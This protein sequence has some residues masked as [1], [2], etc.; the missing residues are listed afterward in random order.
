[1]S[2]LGKLGLTEE[3]LHTNWN[4]PILQEEARDQIIKHAKRYLKKRGEI[5]SIK[6]YKIG[7]PKGWVC[8]I[9]FS[10]N[11]TVL[12]G[13]ARNCYAD[14]YTHNLEDMKWGMRGGAYYEHI[15]RFEKGKG[16]I[17]L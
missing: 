11:S 3:E 12:M 8:L 16:E 17:L 14:L 10:N 7:F 2:V 13:V 5:T 15:F 9:S 1:M 6:G 4:K